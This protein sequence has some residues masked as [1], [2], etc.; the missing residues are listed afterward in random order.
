M[1]QDRHIYATVFVASF[2]GLGFEITLTRIFSISLWY[3]F[4]FMV[5]TIAMMGL[6]LSGTVLALLPG[7]KSYSNLGRY[8]LFLGISI[9]AAYLISNQIPFDPVKFQWSNAHFLLIGLYYLVLLFPFLFTGLIIATGYHLISKKSGLL[10]GTDLLGAAMGSLGI[11]LLLHHMAPDQVILSLSAV[12][13]ISIPLKESKAIRIGSISLF[14]VII[15]LMVL[16]PAFLTTRISPFKEMPLALRYPGARHINTHYDA[17]SRIDIF[18]SPAVRYAP[19]LSLKYL[20]PLPHQLGC[21][22]DGDR[23]MAI[24]DAR[25]RENLDFLS[26]LPQAL[27]FEV[28][29]KKDAL[30]IDP[31]GGLSTLMARYYGVENTVNVE[32]YPLLVKIL[33]TEQ[34]PFSG[35][36]YSRST[37]SGLGRAWLKP[38]SRMFDVID[39]T[40]TKS[41]PSGPSGLSEDYQLTVEAFQEYLRHLKKEGFLCLSLY[42]V[43]PPRHSFR[44]LTTMVAAME[45]SGIPDPAAHIAAIRSWGTMTIL[46]KRTRLRPSDIKRIKDFAGSRLF[47]LVYYPGIQA[48]ETGRFI[49]TQDNLYYTGIKKIL[50]TDK[51]GRFVDRYVFDISPVT[52]DKPFFY[53][54]L[55]FGNIKKV[56]HLVGEKWDFFLREGTLVPFMFL[57]IVVFSFFLIALPRLF[58]KKAEI[59]PGHPRFNRSLAVYFALLGLGFM[60]IEIV[61]IQKLILVLTNPMISVA[62]VLASVLMGA[63]LGGMMNTRFP[64]LRKPVCLLA[65]PALIIL[66]ALLQSPLTGFLI[67]LPLASKLPLIFLFILPLGFSLGLPFPTAMRF[68]GEH[69]PEFIPRAW[70]VNGCFSVMGPILAM[71]IALSLGFSAVLWAGGLL[72]LAAALLFIRIHGK[73][74]RN[75]SQQTD[76]RS[77]ETGISGSG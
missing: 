56:Y 76:L 67:S 5:I 54:F 49:K 57:Q 77:P 63:G 61:L 58:G 53:Y 29:G 42:L 17:F 26:H 70:A 12:T 47:D 3:H 27:V 52:D 62:A 40:L 28:A 38:R 46:M 18:E 15:T 9:T 60:F 55:K 66:T 13:L 4:A 51:T 14:L 65:I 41:I 74:T 48:R 69:R 10:Y 24:T 33:Q 25:N 34:A 11:L 19:G 30:V 7:L 23:I 16:R 71:M 35:Y 39:M 64:F 20:R 31:G 72:Y 43:P 36:L 45:K 59:G 22:I 21:A 68:L 73:Q 1:R 75:T 37:R 8:R 6:A 2:A 44:L 32:S 50:G